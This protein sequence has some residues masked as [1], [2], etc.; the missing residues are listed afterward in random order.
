MASKQL[1][2]VRSMAWQPNCGTGCRADVG[3]AAFS[4]EVANVSASGM[5]T[6]LAGDACAYV[7]LL[8]CT[9]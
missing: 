6:H 4:L 2:R 1:S 5:V 9:L 3:N 8:G 7:P